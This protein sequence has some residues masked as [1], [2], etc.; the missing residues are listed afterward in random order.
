MSTTARFLIAHAH[1]LAGTT[2]FYF[3]A[4]IMRAENLKSGKTAVWHIATQR[5]RNRLAKSL[6]DAGCLVYMDDE[7]GAMTPDYNF[8]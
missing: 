5:E 2:V 7:T 8:D 6:E 1:E 4:Y 3:A